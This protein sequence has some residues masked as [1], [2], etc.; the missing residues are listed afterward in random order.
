MHLLPACG[1]DAYGRAGAGCESKSSTKA[2]PH[3]PVFAAL[4]PPPS[5]SALY[6]ATAARQGG[7][8]A[9]SRVDSSEF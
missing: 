2:A 5:I 7:S 1:L 6:P 4:N 8:V 3:L 9:A